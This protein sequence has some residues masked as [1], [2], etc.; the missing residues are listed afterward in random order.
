MN[1]FCRKALLIKKIY[2]GFG[3]GLVLNEFRYWPCS[4]R[5]HRLVCWEERTQIQLTAEQ[6][7]AS[8]HSMW[9]HRGTRRTMPYSNVSKLDYLLIAWG[10]DIKTNNEF[11]NPAWNKIYGLY[12]RKHFIQSLQT[13]C[14]NKPCK[15]DNPLFN[16]LK[17]SEH[18]MIV[19]IS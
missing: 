17:Y 3:M 10:Q 9:L 19:G 16:Y 11:L 15:T 6:W 5:G 14:C 18:S 1:F 4:H 13:S 7:M 8:L 12:K 2:N